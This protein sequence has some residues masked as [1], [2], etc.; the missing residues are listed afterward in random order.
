MARVERGNVVLQ[1][2]ERDVDYY[3]N[4]GYSLTDDNGNVL[5]KAIPSNV[6]E[7]QKAYLEHIQRISE[8]ENTVAELT[9]KLT[10]KKSTSK[11][12]QS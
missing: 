5:K 11:K 1:V 7:L 2:D 6:G 4:M 10:A 9:A 12:S 8:L 3:I